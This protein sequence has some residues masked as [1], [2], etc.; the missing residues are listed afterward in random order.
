[1]SK[2]TTYTFAYETKTKFNINTIH[3]Y[4]RIYQHIVLT[5][6]QLILKQEKKQRVNI[7]LFEFIRKS[8][9]IYK[10][11]QERDLQFEVNIASLPDM[12]SIHYR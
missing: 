3:I 6:Y 10:D 1:M 4:T 8:A 9:D 2:G 12:C 11:S 7:K 5:I